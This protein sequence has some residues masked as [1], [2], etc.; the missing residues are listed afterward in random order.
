MIITLDVTNEVGRPLLEHARAARAS[1]EALVD[2]NARV[3]RAKKVP[4]LYSSGVRY[5]KPVEKNGRQPILGALETFKSGRGSCPELSAW[6]AAE[7]RVFGDAR[8]G[9]EPCRKNPKSGGCHHGYIRIAASGEVVC[10]CPNV[11]LYWRPEC[12]GVIHCEVR[13]PDGNAEDPSRFL[14]MTG[15]PFRGGR[16]VET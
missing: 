10:A 3:I 13:L 8:I 16:R 7:L 2:D 14:G 12:R 11:K 6:R 4:P 15:N 5:R 9:V 1:L